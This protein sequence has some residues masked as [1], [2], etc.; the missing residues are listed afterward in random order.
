[1]LRVTCYVLRFTLYVIRLE[2]AIS[3]H[4]VEAP[5]F[6]HTPFSEYLNNK[7]H[8]KANSSLHFFVTEL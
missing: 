3:Q 5:T 4:N 2:K 1:M 6:L 8:V 7:E